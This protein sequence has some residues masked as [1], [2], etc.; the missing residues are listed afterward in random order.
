[1]KIIL[2]VV[3]SLDGKTTKW[4][5]PDVHTLSSKEDQEYFFSTLNKNKLIIMG[6]RTF[7]VAGPDVYKPPKKLRVVITRSPK[8]YK[9]IDGLLEFTNSSPKKLIEKQKFR[10]VRFLR[11]PL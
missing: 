10:L 9:N 4:N 8:K 6:R 3:I 5:L 1:M 11:P 2:V 7:E